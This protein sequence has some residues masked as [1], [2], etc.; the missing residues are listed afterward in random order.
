MCTGKLLSKCESQ[1]ANNCS[2]Y[3]HNTVTAIS[4]HVLAV[5][6]NS[7]YFRMYDLLVRP[8][9][10]RPIYVQVSAGKDY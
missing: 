7:D 5:I 4:T 10:Y 3:S 1:L 8:S 6:T 2:Q 9:V